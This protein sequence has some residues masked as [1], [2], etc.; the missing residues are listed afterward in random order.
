M[1]Q[2]HACRDGEWEKNLSQPAADRWN[3]G[4]VPPL[5]RA[6]LGSS[7]FRASTR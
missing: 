7:L 6:G 1:G 3:D 5:Y 4:L 2:F